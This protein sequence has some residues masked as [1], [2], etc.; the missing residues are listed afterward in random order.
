ML[1]KHILAKVRL[2]G[3]IALA[4]ASSGIASLLL[5]VER[6]AHSTFKIPLKLNDTSTCSI[7]KQ[8][9]LKGLIQK[10]SLVIW[11]EAPMTTGTLLRLSTG[12]YVPNG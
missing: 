8:S 7:F 11:D 1:L 5:M 2:S 6:T 12:P 3:K 4:V 10:A 9:H